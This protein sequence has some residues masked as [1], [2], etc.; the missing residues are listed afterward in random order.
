MRKP[1]L[2]RQKFVFLRENEKMEKVGCNF[3][4]Q[5]TGLNSTSHTLIMR[6]HTAEYYSITGLSLCFVSG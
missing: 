6:R 1:E 4:L 2:A 3:M 5:T